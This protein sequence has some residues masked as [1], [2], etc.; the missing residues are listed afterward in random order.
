MHIYR[1]LQFKI[2]FFILALFLFFLNGCSSDQHPPK[3]DTKEVNVVVLLPL[4]GAYAHIGDSYLKAIELALFEF[5]DIN[6]KAQILD[7]QGTFEGTLEALKHVKEVDVI[8][9][10]LMST[11]VDAA[12][13]WALKRQ[14]PVISLTNNFTKAQSG[15][16]VFGIPP[17]TEMEELIK[18]AVKNRMD[19]FTVILPSGAFG[20]AMREAI[21]KT[22]SGYGVTLVDVFFYSPNMDEIPSI[23]KQMQKKTV[24]GIIIVNGGQELFTISNALKNA[25]ISGRILGTQQWKNSDVNHWRQLSGS[26]YTT[27]YTSQKQIFENRYF[28]LYNKEPDTTA[29]L[30]YDAMAMLA[31]LHKLNYNSPFAVGALTTPLGFVGL[32]GTFK[33]QKDGSIKRSISIMEIKDGTSHMIGVGEGK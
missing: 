17:Q 7:T 27:S 8:L 21:E 26:W 13:M 14:I 31:K 3:P 15:V 28:S 6:L 24:D 4:S 10:P 33:L 18:F 19:R 9:G 25:K 12:S 29:Y 22:I 20:I 30:A 32:E 5:A 1:S 23:I 11:A 16:F 2:R